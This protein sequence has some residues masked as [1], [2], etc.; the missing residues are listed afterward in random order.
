MLADPY[1][2]S[3]M[4]QPSS[5]YVG[6]TTFYTVDESTTGTYYKWS[7]YKAQPWPAPSWEDMYRFEKGEEAIGYIYDSGATSANKW[8]LASTKFLNSAIGDISIATVSYT[9]LTL[10]TT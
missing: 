5:T 3:S 7:G 8:A 4:A 9:H 2:L 6:I 1:D 10:P